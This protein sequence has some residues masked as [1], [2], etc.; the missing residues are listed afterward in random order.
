[1]SDLLISDDDDEYSVFPLL[2]IKD[3]VSLKGNVFS[4]DYEKTKSFTKLELKA[5]LLEIYLEA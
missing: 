4:T 3:G 1:M 5:D 2:S